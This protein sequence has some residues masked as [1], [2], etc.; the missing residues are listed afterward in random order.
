MRT[1]RRLEARR[2]ET[3]Y[4]P[5]DE[6]EPVLDTTIA[7]VLRDAAAAAPDRP[8]IVA[9]VPDPAQR[10]RRTYAEAVAEAEAVAR[11]LASRCSP[12][13]RVA[14]LAPSIPESYLLTFAAAMARLVLI[15]VNPA[16]RAAEIEHILGTAGAAVAFCVPEHRG[17]DLAGHLAGL[18]PQLPALREVID[19]AEW[20][21]LVEAGRADDRPLPPPDPDDV[22]QLVFTS[23]TTGAPKGAM[24]TH[25]G[26]TN[27][28][29]F[30]GTRFGIG[31]GDVYVSTIPLHHVGGQ[32]LVLMVVQARATNV[33]VTQFDA[34]LQLELIESERATH[35]VGVPTMFQDV[36]DHPTF[37][38]RDVSTLRALSTGGSMVPVEIVR[39]L[40]RSLGVQTTI[41]FGQTETCG[42][43]SQTFPDDDA[44]DKSTTVGPP[45]PQLEARVVD[46]NGGGIVPVGEVGELQVRGVGVTA[47]YFDDPEQTAAALEPDGW[48]HTGDLVTMDDRGYLRVTGRVKEMIVTGGV[49]VYPA[50]IEA[51]L[52]AHPA[53]AQVAVIGVPHERW[54]E[55]VVAV[56][57]P[58]A[59]AAAG[60]SPDP[61][62]LEAFARE[63]LA[64]HKIPK[65]WVF[66]DELPVNASGKVQKY[67]LQETVSLEEAQ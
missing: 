63:R 15:P 25:R 27:R 7:G 59:G 33:L 6:S 43:I 57:R 47:G 21:A 1:R 60:S 50:E 66:V 11:V 32:A 31:P 55:A 65:K 53:V 18:G 17:N 38:D 49:N 10:T 41:I 14:V 30:S 44:E 62:D 58:V 61:S 9:G 16:L 28:S 5:A 2:L 13:D 3:S 37:G 67:L 12:G 54:G 20:P 51:A 36:I 48:L 22:A 56:V 46:P 24:L 40:E 42:Y 34:G 4:W 39:H 23:G 45:L 8:A 26:L 64:P 35:T 29:R 52:G 19:F